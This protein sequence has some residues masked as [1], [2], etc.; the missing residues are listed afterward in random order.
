LLQCFFECEKGQRRKN[1]SDSLVAFGEYSQY[2]FQDKWHPLHTLAA[3]GEFE[4]LDSL[5]KHNVD[6]NAVDKVLQF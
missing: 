5:L 4:L 1:G 6:I 3:C 2:Y